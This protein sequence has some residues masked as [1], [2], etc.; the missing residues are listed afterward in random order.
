VKRGLFSNEAGQGSAPIAH[1][2]AKTKEPVREGA[3]AMLGPLIDTL[4]ICTMTGLVIVTTGVWDEKKQADLGIREV[5]TYAAV[6]IPKKGSS[7][8][9]RV[10]VAVGVAEKADP[11]I[12]VAAL[13]AA[14]RCPSLA[15]VGRDALIDDAV[16]EFKTADGS[17]KPYAGAV[18]LQV[19]AAALKPPTGGAK[20]KFR[21][22]GKMLQNSSALTAWAFQRGLSPIGDWGNLLVTFSVFLFALSTMIS[23]SYYGDRCVEY[24][25]GARFVLP[26]RLVY[27]AFV[28]IGSV[29][30]L[31]IVWDFGDLALGLMAVPN[32]IA[33]VLLMPEVV[34]LSNDYF[35]R[36]AAGGGDAGSGGGDEASTEGAEA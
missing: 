23:W 20:L 12:G 16:L 25:F 7:E 36:M 10:A 11:K 27:V 9:A 14:G 18:T 19:K 31:R 28:F 34:K 3:V 15:F 32:L 13:C 5:K 30:A 21:V 26:Y 1:A 17:F 35:K 24:L 8:A 6:S 29:A 2:A 33:V 22:R 4:I